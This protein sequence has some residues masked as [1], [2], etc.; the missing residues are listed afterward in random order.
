MFSVRERFPF[1]ASTQLFRRHLKIPRETGWVINRNGGSRAG[2]RACSWRKKICHPPDKREATS[3]GFTDSDT[4]A[5]PSRQNKHRARKTR[6]TNSSS[7]SSVGSNH[8][9]PSGL[10]GLPP[11]ASWGYCRCCC[12]CCCCCWYWCYHDRPQPVWLLIAREYG[13]IDFC[14]SEAHSGQA[15]NLSLGAGERSLNIPPVPSIAEQSSW[16]GGPT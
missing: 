6:N 13:R 11:H 7:V 8:E 15:K 4:H 14:L 5:T 16:S 2:R 9:P 10:V 3:R 12:W 1:N